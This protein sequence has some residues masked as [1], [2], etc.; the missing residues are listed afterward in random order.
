MQRDGNDHKAYLNISEFSFVKRGMS[1]LPD[2]PIRHIPHPSPLRPALQR[3]LAV[4]PLQSG[5]PPLAS[6]ASRVMIPQLPPKRMAYLRR[7]KAAVSCHIFLKIWDCP[8]HPHQPISADSPLYRLFLRIQTLK[9]AGER[10]PR[11][12]LRP[13]VVGCRNPDAL[14]KVNGAVAISWQGCVSS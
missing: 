13:S 8:S 6:R 3:H 4:P 12:F 1:T 9:L 11:P 7:F 14:T 5:L 10:F 2:I